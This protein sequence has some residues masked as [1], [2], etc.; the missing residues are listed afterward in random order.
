MSQSDTPVLVL[1]S[2]QEATAILSIMEGMLAVL[3]D[4]GLKDSP[5]GEDLEDARLWLSDAVKGAAYP[6]RLPV[7]L[8]AGQQTMLRNAVGNVSDQGNFW[9][10]GEGSETPF[11]AHIE[12]YTGNP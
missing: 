2:E 1:A 8:S 6:A 7:E 5:D 9:D 11:T 3:D 12:N 10:D 4:D